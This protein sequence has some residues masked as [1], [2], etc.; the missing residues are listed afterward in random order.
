[1]IFRASPSTSP[2]DPRPAARPGPRRRCSLRSPV[3]R[4]C[5]A[6]RLEALGRRHDHDVTLER[7]G[8]D[9]QGAFFLPSAVSPRN[10]GHH[11]HRRPRLAGG[12]LTP[13]EVSGISTAWI[14]ALWALAAEKTRSSLEEARAGR[15]AS[16]TAMCVQSRADLGD[17]GLHLSFSCVSR[18]GRALRPAT[19]DVHQW[20]WRNSSKAP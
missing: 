4:P 7:L 8:P 1:L 17:R 18:R 10:R 11:R 5:G 3:H 6:A 19:R 2:N 13:L 14:A 20:L 9:A 12:P 16:W 15:A